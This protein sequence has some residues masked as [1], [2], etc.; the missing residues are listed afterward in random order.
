MKTANKRAD[1]FKAFHRK[2]V[3]QGKPAPLTPLQ[4]L[5]ALIMA[6]LSYD[7]EDE[8]AQSAWQAFDRV[9]VDPNE[10]RVATELELQDLMGQRYPAA[11][12]RAAALVSILN[13]IFEREHTLNLERVKELRKAEIRQFFRDLPGMTPFIEAYTFTYGFEGTGAVAVDQCIVDF[14]VSQELLPADSSHADAQ[15]FV[16]HHVKADESYSAYAVLRAMALASPTKK[17]K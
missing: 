15:K 9:F 17:K 14:L 11:E 13:A 10:L 7:V 2:A 4:P 8:R 1:K 16:E 12:Q 5:V 3:R 6:V